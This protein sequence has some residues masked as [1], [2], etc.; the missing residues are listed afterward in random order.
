MF[1]K[2]KIF[3]AFSLALLSFS[4]H[5]FS[6]QFGNPVDS[7]KLIKISTVMA[8]PDDYLASPITVEGTITGVCEKRGCWMTLASDKRFENLRIKVEDGDM[9]FPMTAKGSKAIVTGKLDK[10]QL[11]LGRTKALLAHKAQQA[12]ESF[13]ANS[14]TE[15][16]AIYQLVP[17]GVEII[18]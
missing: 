14:V 11:S 17:S 13:D 8:T 3:I 15:A 9:V 1:L 7:D 6:L 2:S 18:E 16:M 10:I 12:G 4:Q 5:A